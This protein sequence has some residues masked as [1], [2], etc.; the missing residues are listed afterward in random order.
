MMMSNLIS[1]NSSK[2]FLLSTI[3][4]T[5]GCTESDK[6]LPPAALSAIEFDNVFVDNLTRGI[7]TT[8][9]ID[10]FKLY[11]FVDNPSSVI[12]NGVLV[13]KKGDSWIPSKTEYWYP[14]H[15]YRFSGIAPAH[16]T[17]GWKFLPATS[18]PEDYYGGGVLEF[19]IS[20]AHGNTDLLYAYSSCISTPE[21]MTEPMPPVAMDF[22]HM[23]SRVHFTY[24]NELGNH[25]YFINVSTTQLRNVCG[26]ASIDLTQENG[27]WQQKDYAT[28]WIDL[29]GVIVRTDAP[30]TTKEVFL[31]PCNISGSEI[32]IQ[33]QI[34]YTPEDSGTQGYIFSDMATQTVKLPEVDFKPGYTYNFIAHLTADNVLGDGEK[35]YP[36]TFTVTE[37][38]R[39]DSTITI[40][41]P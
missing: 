11:G 31:I 21:I 10:A 2:I 16:G 24:I 17:S 40:D 6:D 14:G 28:A 26:K 13:S 36:I 34:F 4:L 12:F 41:T 9:N 27:S 1:T 30:A 20:H 22:R 18:L 3:L 37:S 33:T 25:H 38:P 8:E 39:W 35:L 32:Y 23:L 7:I 19:D 15:Q 29:D 5:A